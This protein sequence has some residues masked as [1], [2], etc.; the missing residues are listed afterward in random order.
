MPAN[1]TPQYLKAEQAYREAKT[2]DDKLAALEE[3][4]ALIPKHKGTDHMCADLKRKI[5]QLRAMPRTKAGARRADP[6]YI[7]RGGTGRAVVFG[8]PNVGKSALVAA[9]TRAHVEVADYPFTTKVPVPGMMPFHDIHVQ[10]V[11]MPPITADDI[12]PGMMGAV[13][14]ADVILIVV[15]LSASDLLEQLET[16]TRQLVDRNI[17]LI[18]E[19]LPLNEEPIEAEGRRPAIVLC[20]KCDLDPDGGNFQ[21]LKD[22]SGCKLPM[23]AVSAQRRINLEAM[24]GEIVRLLDVVRVYSKRPGKP[25]DME[26][27]F[28]LKRGSTVL[29]LARMVHRDLPSQLKFA[30][31]WGSAKF[32]GQQVQIDYVLVDR[33]I[34]ELHT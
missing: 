27:P 8:L 15:D 31:I 7:E 29:D 11:D 21:A 6:F 10:L 5:A 3:M 22:L 2:P 23:F 1:L 28:V 14:S 17:E 9:V 18:G 4:L 19:P 16:T 32:D 20:N 30:R 34:I 25:P 26:E 33:D 24:A 13:R 12:L